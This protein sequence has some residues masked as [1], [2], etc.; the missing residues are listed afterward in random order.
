MTSGTAREPY[1]G[2]R[3]ALRIGRRVRWHHP[4][5]P[6]ALAAA[7]AWVVL[8]AGSARPAG[9]V[10]ATGHAGLHGAGSTEA[11][12]PVAG[13]VV[14]SAAMM[15]PAVLPTARAVALTSR[16]TRRQRALGVY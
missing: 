9:S 16:W 13:W 12:G 5:W 10:P 14:M 6:V 8:L 11:A 2:L 7:A 4:E 15:L 1:E 3:T